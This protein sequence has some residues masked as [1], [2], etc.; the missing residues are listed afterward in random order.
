MVISVES[1]T[2]VISVNTVITTLAFNEP[3]A[4]CDRFEQIVI[5]KPQNMN[6]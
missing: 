1:K 2:M 4:K 5:L 6:H 3:I